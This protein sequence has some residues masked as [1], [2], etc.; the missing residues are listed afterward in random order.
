MDRQILNKM[1]LSQL[2]KEAQRYGLSATGDK[3]AV[4]DSLLVHFERYGPAIDFSDD[5]QGARAEAASREPLDRVLVLESREEE[6]PRCARLVSVESARPEMTRTSLKQMLTE[7]TADMRQQ[8][9]DMLQ[10]QKQLMEQQQQQFT[11]LAQ[12]LLAQQ[13]PRETRRDENP[14]SAVTDSDRA[15]T[16]TDSSP[17]NSE[18]LRVRE[19]GSL[20]PG[21]MVQWLASHIPEFAGAE[22]DNVLA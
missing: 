8:H 20:P 11:Q 12:I 16:T 13:K 5:E 7:V 15:R 22:D 17:I 6:E 19:R 9:V 4:I 18:Q 1:T 10:H 21:N 3:N 14:P 2:R